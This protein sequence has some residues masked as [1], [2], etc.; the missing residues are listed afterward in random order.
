MIYDCSYG[1]VFLLWG[2]PAAKKAK[3]VD[4][5]KHVVIQTSHPSPLGASKTKSPF[6]GS[7]CFSRT[8]KALTQG[9]KEPIIWDVN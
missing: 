1:V 7:R 5:S 4:Q 3:G 9:G 8:N 6:L 2:A